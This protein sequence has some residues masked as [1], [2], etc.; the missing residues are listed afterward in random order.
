MGISA[1]Q[2][3]DASR[4]C[5]PTK[6]QKLLPWK[7]PN[8]SWIQCSYFGGYVF[9][10]DFRAVFLENHWLLGLDHWK[11]LC[12]LLKRPLFSDER[13]LCHF[14]LHWTNFHQFEWPLQ[15]R[16][17]DV[18]NPMLLVFTYLLSHTIPI[19]YSCP[20]SSGCPLLT[21]VAI[22]NAG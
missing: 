9:F 5:F 17:A 20:T 14:R 3:G 4:K 12:L 16:S 22:T 2:N 11:H 8:K 15:L 6:Y 21:H 7:R 10:L 1:I 13:V 19:Q 18:S